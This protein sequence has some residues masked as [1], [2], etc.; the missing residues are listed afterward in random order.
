MVV[1]DLGEGGAYQVR[2]NCGRGAF[3]LVLGCSPVDDKNTWRAIKKFKVIE[4]EDEPSKALRDKKNQMLVEKAHKEANSLQIVDHHMII[5]GY[6]MF[7]DTKK[8]PCII[9]EYAENGHYK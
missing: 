7:L 9:M 1:L 6:G 3:G 4:A 2:S 5:K 8:N